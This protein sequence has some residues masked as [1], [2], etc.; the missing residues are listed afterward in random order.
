[1]PLKCMFFP[2]FQLWGY[3]VGAVDWR[4]SLQGHRRRG[5]CLRG[6][7]QQIQPPHSINLPN[8]GTALKRHPNLGGEISQAIVML[9]S[10]SSGG[11]DRYEIN[12]IGETLYSSV[13]PASS[14]VLAPNPWKTVLRFQDALKSSWRKLWLCEHTCFHWFKHWEPP[15]LPVRPSVSLVSQNFFNESV[16][17]PCLPVA[18]PDGILLALRSWKPPDIQRRPQGSGRD[19][20]VKVPP[21]DQ[22]FRLLLNARRLE[23]GNWRHAQKHSR[24]GT[25][26]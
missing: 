23:T 18:P 17:L 2:L 4:G 21:D 1:M 19:P 14:F 20:V 3:D 22:R 24:Q 13:S 9:L 25:C 6:R 5:H 15:F 8:T 16:L 10:A 7:H 26:K 11:H 12:L